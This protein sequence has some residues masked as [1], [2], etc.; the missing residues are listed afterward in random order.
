MG[1]FTA[2][3]DAL[4]TAKDAGASYVAERYAAQWVEPYGRMLNLSIDSK[5]K[6][7]RVEILPKGETSP[8]AVTIEEYEITLV[9][10]VES[11]LIKRASA[12]REWVDAVLKDFATGKSIALPEKYATVLK[13]VL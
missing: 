13:T 11:I 2:I 12:S 1:L 7:I 4:H 10:G 8:L 9:K 3:K 6:K 5:N